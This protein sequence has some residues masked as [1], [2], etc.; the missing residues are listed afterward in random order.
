MAKNVRISDGLYA[1]AQAEAALQER[2]IAQQLEYWAKL[3]LAAT[4]PGRAVAAA[5]PAQAAAAVT[6][7]LDRLDVVEGRRRAEDMHFVPRALAARCE[8]RFPAEYRKS[9]AGR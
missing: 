5:I 7:R 8:P 3:G 9:R 4:E 2:S 1:L 6:R